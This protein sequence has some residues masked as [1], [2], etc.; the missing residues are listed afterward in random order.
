MITFCEIPTNCP[1]LTCWVKFIPMLKNSR[2]HKQS[3]AMIGLMCD[4][5]TFLKKAVLITHNRFKLPAFFTHLPYE[6]M[7]G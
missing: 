1:F 5:P 6:H 2:F 7:V 3:I 4:L